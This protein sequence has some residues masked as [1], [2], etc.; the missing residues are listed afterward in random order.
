MVY[1]QVRRG[2]LDKNAKKQVSF[3]EKFVNTMNW[4]DFKK[5]DWKIAT[6]LYLK[7]K[8]SGYS[9]KHQ[10]ADILI[11]AQAK[12]IEAMVFTNNRKDFERLGIETWKEE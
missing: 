6:S 12:R 4:L 1:Y 9:P 10:D 2:L 11:A 5:R 7:L 8:R 3:F